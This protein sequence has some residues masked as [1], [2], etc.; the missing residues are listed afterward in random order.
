M[1]YIVVLSYLFCV[2][3]E[4]ISEGIMNCTGREGNMKEF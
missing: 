3:E 4:E 1:G 2:E